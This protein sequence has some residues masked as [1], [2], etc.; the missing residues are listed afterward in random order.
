MTANR[1][2]KSQIVFERDFSVV[3]VLGYLSEMKT[4]F[5]TSERASKYSI[6]CSY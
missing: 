1:T 4:D 3:C 2:L 6:A 5:Y